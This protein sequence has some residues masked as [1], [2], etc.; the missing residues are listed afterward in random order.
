VNIILVT[1]SRFWT[2]YSIIHNRLANEPR[3]TIVLQGGC[4]T[5]ADNMAYKAAIALGFM[6]L[7]LDANWHKNGKA[8]GPIRN[9]AMAEIFTHL[10]DGG[11]GEPFHAVA[12]LKKGAA[13][14]GTRDCISALQDFGRFV[15]E[16]EG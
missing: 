5:G 6:P 4:K 15:E 2:D 16:I 3:G 1:G 12:F 7:T 13:N 8:A 14:K 11:A 10:D 9:Q